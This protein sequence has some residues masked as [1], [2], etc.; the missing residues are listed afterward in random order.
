MEKC[1]KNELHK[2][3][4]YIVSSLEVLVINSITIYL[5]RYTRIFKSS[6]IRA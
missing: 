5:S 6:N 4:V 3:S 1:S 2:I